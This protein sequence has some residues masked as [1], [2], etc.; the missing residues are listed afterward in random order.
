MIGDSLTFLLWVACFCL[1][2]TAIY[3]KIRSLRIS[4]NI[5]SGHHNCTI[6]RT[7]ISGMISVILLRHS[8]L[9]LKEWHCSKN[10]WWSN[11][12]L[13]NKSG[14]PLYTY[15]CIICKKILLTNSFY[16]IGH[17]YKTVINFINLWINIFNL[18]IFKKLHLSQN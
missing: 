11:T 7:F 8:T 10:K 17:S 15:V 6:V 16:L 2:N 12:S 4:L 14:D 5:F 1:P 18:N 13:I 3:S 9:F